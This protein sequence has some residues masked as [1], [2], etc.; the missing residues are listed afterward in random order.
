MIALSMQED[1]HPQL[2]I[3]KLPAKFGPRAPAERIAVRNRRALGCAMSGATRLTEDASEA[4][5]SLET[6]CIGHVALRK[7]TN[8]LVPTPRV[9]GLSEQQG[10]HGKH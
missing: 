9:R 3:V 6:R 1:P 7:E 2:A 8:A 4:A 5:K 10:H